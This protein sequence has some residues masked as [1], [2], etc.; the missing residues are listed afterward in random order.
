VKRNSEQELEL[1]KRLIEAIR[2]EQIAQEQEDV[3]EIEVPQ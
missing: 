1:M 2:A 3:G